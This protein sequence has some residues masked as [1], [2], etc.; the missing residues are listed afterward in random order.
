VA[1]KIGD[2]DFISAYYA[3]NNS[4]DIYELDKNEYV[5]TR[6]EMNRLL[7]LKMIV[8]GY[9]WNDETLPCVGR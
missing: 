5:E 7:N 9:L 2:E 6:F 4:V 3:L 1:G 8:W